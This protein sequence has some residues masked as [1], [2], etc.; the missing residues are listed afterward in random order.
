MVTIAKQCT[1]QNFKTS[2]QTLRQERLI[3]KDRKQLDEMIE[4]I[5]ALEE[6]LEIVPEN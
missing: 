4:S 1:I 2:S 3:Q 6:L 5:S